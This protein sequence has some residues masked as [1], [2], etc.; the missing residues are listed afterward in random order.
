[1]TSREGG[2]P[3]IPPL[4]SCLEVIG[5]RVSYKDRGEACSSLAVFELV[6]SATMPAT[7]G[8]QT[9]LNDLDGKIDRLSDEWLRV[10]FKKRRAKTEARKG[11]MK[12]RMVLIARVIKKMQSCRGRMVQIDEA[13]GNSLVRQRVKEEMEACLVD[14]DKMVEFFGQ[15]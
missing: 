12:R 13:F 15:F 10:Q 1:M 7:R 11:L 14:L 8:F 9:I 4:T 2:Y 3:S 6:L 5:G